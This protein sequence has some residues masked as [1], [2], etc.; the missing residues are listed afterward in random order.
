MNDPRRRSRLLAARSSCALAF[1]LVARS[2]AADDD[3]VR[4][5]VREQLTGALLPSHG[6]GVSGVC[7]TGSGVVPASIYA[8]G[9]SGRGAGMGIGVGGRVAYHHP[10]TTPKARGT[11]W[12]GL[13]FAAGLDLNLLYAKVD[14]GIPDVAGQLCARVKSDGTDVQYKGSTVLLLQLPAFVGAEL[15]LGARGANEHEIVLGV[16]WAPAI[17]YLQPWVTSGDLTAGLLGTEIT[18]DFVGPSDGD[19][20]P[21]TKRAAVFLLLPVKDQGPVIMTVSFGVVWY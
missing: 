11:T 19:R 16:G 17:T 2:A 7:A 13:R 8:H 9:G 20:H 10:L 15:G 1:A 3:A 6:Y 5:E 18:V 14:V 21:T 4:Y 12:W